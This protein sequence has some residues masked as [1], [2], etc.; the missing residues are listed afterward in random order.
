MF[1]VKDTILLGLV[2]K[3][4]GRGRQLGFPTANIDPSQCLLISDKFIFSLTDAM[5]DITPAS[6]TF[7]AEVL[8]REATRRIL[9]TQDLYADKSSGELFLFLHRLLSEIFLSTD[10]SEASGTAANVKLLTK[11]V[12]ECFRHHNFGQAQNTS[13]NEDFL[14]NMSDGVYAAQVGGVS[15]QILSAA[16]SLGT[17]EQFYDQGNRIIE[18]HLIDAEMNLYDRIICLHVRYFIRHQKKFEN[19]AQL[20]EAI[21]EDVDVSRR[22][23]VS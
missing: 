4:D 11:E 3:G 7:E 19:I 8:V 6:T 9:D 14:S 1:E 15:D 2:V 21:Q 13:F 5:K 16:V 12:L 20:I 10:S 23:L 22:L 18:A 17:R